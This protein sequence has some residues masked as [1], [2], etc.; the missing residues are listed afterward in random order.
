MIFCDLST[1][2]ADGFDVYN[3]I[4]DKLVARGIPKEEVQ[5]IHDA[6]TEAK[7]AELFGKVRSGA[8]RV[9]MGSTQ[10]WALAPTYRRGCAHSITLIAHGGQP[11]LPSATDAWC[12][13]VTRTKRFL[14]LFI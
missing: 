6:D 2:R 1:P 8:V 3:D 4:R 5:F 7:K 9:L 11:I 14:S 13:R 12:G 10:R